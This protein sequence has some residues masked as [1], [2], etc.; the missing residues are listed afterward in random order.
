MK[1]GRRKVQDMN[2]TYELTY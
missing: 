1:H 2:L